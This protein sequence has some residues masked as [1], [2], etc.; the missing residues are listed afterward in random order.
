MTFWDALYRQSHI[1]NV[2]KKALVATQLHH[3]LSQV[4]VVN[5]KAAD[6][7]ASPAKGVLRLLLERDGGE[8]TTR[9]T[10]LVTYQP[11]SRFEPHVHPKGE[12]FVVLSGT[13]SDEHGDYPAGTYVRNPPGSS[14]QPFSRDGCLILVKL[15]QFDMADNQHIVKTVDMSKYSC[16]L[17][18]GWRQQVLFSGYENVSFVQS[19]EPCAIPVEWLQRGVEILV[20]SGGLTMVEGEAGVY[21]DGYTGDEQYHGEGSWLRFPA[22]SEQYCKANI[23]AEKDTQLWVKTGHLPEIVVVDGS[24]K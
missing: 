18:D 7:V 4:A 14:H 6:W 9:A 12:E 17:V 19:V 2:D 3:D 24:S 13:F 5:V 22:C 10:S 20:M 16:E 15:Q 11:N 1:A 8:K 23:I 21:I